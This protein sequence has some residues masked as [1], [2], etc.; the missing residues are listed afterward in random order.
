[1]LPFPTLE[2]AGSGTRHGLDGLDPPPLLIADAAA[3]LSRPT[4]VALAGDGPTP[5]FE[6]SSA[7]YAVD[8]STRPATLVLVAGVEERI[9]RCPQRPT[10]CPVRRLRWNAELRR[11]A[12]VSPRDTTRSHASP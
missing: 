6:G 1:M 9:A 12:P 4:L 8:I 3:E 5:I 10:R 7:D 2:E 11:L